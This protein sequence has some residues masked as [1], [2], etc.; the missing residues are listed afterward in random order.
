MFPKQRM[1]KKP[2]KIKGV[3][4]GPAHKTKAPGTHLKG[5]CRLQSNRR[6]GKVEGTAA[7]QPRPQQGSAPHPT[8]TATPQERCVAEKA[9]LHRSVDPPYPSFAVKGPPTAGDEAGMW[10]WMGED[11]RRI[12]SPPSLTLPSPHSRGGGTGQA[13]EAKVPPGPFAGAAAPQHLA[14]RAL[15]GSPPRGRTPEGV[16][17]PGPGTD[18]RTKWRGAAVP[19][20]GPVPRGNTPS[21]LPPREVPHTAYRIRQR[22]SR[23]ARRGIG[24]RGHL[25]PPC[26]GERASGA[27]SSANGG[28]DPEMSEGKPAVRPGRGAGRPG[29]APPVPRDKQQQQPPPRPQTPPKSHETRRPGFAHPALLAAAPHAEPQASPAAPADLWRKDQLQRLTAPSRDVCFSLPLGAKKVFTLSV[30]CCNVNYSTC[31]CAVVAHNNKAFCGLLLS[32]D[33]KKKSLIPAAPLRRLQKQTPA[34]A[35]LFAPAP[36]ILVPR[37]HGPAVVPEERCTA[38]WACTKESPGLAR[39]PRAVGFP[40]TQ[41]EIHQG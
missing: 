26:P 5:A 11:P 23:A 18:G 27:A 1:L 4:S 13:D 7:P 38:P 12:Q 39:S 21:A 36:G 31:A 14:C 17:P 37:P 33:W 8:A 25:R 35:A 3:R 2:E 34:C 10:L 22:G 28:S 9:A 24:R 20:R 15:V 40:V 29:P 41:L 19:L 6:R 16:R 30:A 32:K